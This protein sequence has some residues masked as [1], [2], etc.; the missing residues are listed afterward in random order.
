MEIA[1][2]LNQ[3][4]LTTDSEMEQSTSSN[5][6]LWTFLREFQRQDWSDSEWASSQD[7]PLWHVDYFEPKAMETLQAQEKLLPLP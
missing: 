1:Q 6:G 7:M 3:A 2:S 4:V 5:S